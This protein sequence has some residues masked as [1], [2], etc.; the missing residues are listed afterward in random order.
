MNKEFYVTYK[1]PEEFVP[2]EFVVKV[3]AETFDEA[4]SKMFDALNNIDL[5]VEP[6]IVN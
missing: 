6:V 5:N 4:A 2:N 3:S 1:L